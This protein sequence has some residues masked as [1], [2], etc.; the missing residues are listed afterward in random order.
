MKRHSSGPDAGR[1]SRSSAEAADRRVLEEN[2]ALRRQVRQMVGEAQRNESALRRFQSL[3]LD[4]LGSESLASLLTLL[5]LDA[6]RRC[7]W[8]GVSLFLLDPQYEIRRLLGQTGWESAV[9]S[10]LVFVDTPERLDALHGRRCSPRLGLYLPSRHD[11]LFRM[12]E[13]PV[14]SVA[15]LPIRRHGRL[16]GSYNL[17]SY[18]PD[19]FPRNA[20]SDFLHHLGAVIAACLEI[21]VTRD[22]L[23]HL[24][25]A[26][27]LTG[28]NNRRFFNQRL[29]EEIARASRGGAP[30][31]CLFIDV[32]HFKHFND[33]YGHQAGDHVLR[34]VAELVRS[35][36][37][38]S[39]ILA[40]YGGE[41]FAALLPET[42][43]HS[44]A[45][46]SERV[47]DKI[48]SA[49]FAVSGDVAAS[50]TVSIGVATLDP[51]ASD[52]EPATLGIRL[53]EAA[54]RG[55]YRAKRDGRNRVFIQP[56]G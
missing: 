5:M 56:L 30:L 25:L 2:A 21:G 46:I 18:S 24:G 35:L 20:A 1:S 50:V 36:L 55:V 43:L 33:R 42:N 3:E 26:D 28:I 34:E 54:D 40:R 51:D 12:M 15:L 53:V 22:R 52:P 27:A 9:S 41:E 14:A 47:R 19:R 49:R 11:D 23:Q 29:P 7:E 44:A 16:F 6:P 39:D 10:E 13:G 38:R 17:G 37:R 4:L 48:A 31:S 32:D 45:V 8:D